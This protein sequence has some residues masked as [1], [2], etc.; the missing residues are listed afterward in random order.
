LQFLKDNMALNITPKELKVPQCIKFHKLF[1]YLEWNCSSHASYCTQ[2]RMQKA[3]NVNNDVSMNPAIRNH[4]KK[5]ILVQIDE[6]LMLF[7]NCV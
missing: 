1:I 7:A 2:S 3:K 6:Q 5:L 4:V